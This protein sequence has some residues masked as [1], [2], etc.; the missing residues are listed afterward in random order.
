[1]PS[2]KASAQFRLQTTEE[3]EGSSWFVKRKRKASSQVGVELDSWDCDP[4]P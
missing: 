3:K 2:R 4:Y 1:M